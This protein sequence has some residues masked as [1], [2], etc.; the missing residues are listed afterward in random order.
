MSG[1]EKSNTEQTV[2]LSVVFIT[3]GTIV[4]MTVCT[5]W[6]IAP[7]TMP[8]PLYAVVERQMSQPG[9]LPTIAAVAQMPPFPTVTPVPAEQVVL[10]P[11]SAVEENPYPDYFVSAETAVRRQPGVNEPQRILIPSI[12]LNAPVSPI[13]LEAINSAN[14]ESYYQWPVPNE[15]RAGWHDN[16]AR[17]GQPGNTVLNGHHN[18][19]GQVFR[20]L[21]DL[22][23]G[24]EIMIQDGTGQQFTYRVTETEIFLERDQPLEVRLE[25]ARWINPTD[26]ERLTLVTCW[27]FTDNSHRLVVVAHPVT[28]EE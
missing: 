1:Q 26:D 3:I 20:S 8:A 2:P 23:E 18:I 16:S 5:V 19:Y 9:I 15:F 17:L 10:L 28:G 11:E 7:Y 6:L 22:N 12:N 27:P 24:D 21:I 4:L 14:G 13:S 25:N